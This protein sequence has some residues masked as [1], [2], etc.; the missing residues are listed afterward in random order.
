[1]SKFYTN[2]LPIKKL[3]SAIVALIFVQGIAYAQ[4]APNPKVKINYKVARGMMRSYNTTTLAIGNT[5]GA[6]TETGAIEVR[7]HAQFR[8]STG[9]TNGS[10]ASYNATNT[11]PSGTC[12]SCATGTATKWSC[13][14]RCETATNAGSCGTWVVNGSQNASYPGDP[15]YVDTSSYPVSD[16]LEVQMKGFETDNF[17]TILNGDKVNFNYN[18]GACQSTC[19]NGNCY[20]NYQIPTSGRFTNIDVGNSSNALA[21]FCG[22]NWSANYDAAY[23]GINCA[24]DLSGYRAY[25]YLQWQYR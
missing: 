6:C 16:V 21:P 19:A 17:N 7:V 5:G 12:L 4:Y 25:Y 3:V 15:G 11:C 9:I 24:L 22:S 18:D 10:N 20:G 13:E 1:M 2:I 23:E 8:S 14:Q